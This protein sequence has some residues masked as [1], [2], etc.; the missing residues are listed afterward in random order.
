MRRLFHGLGTILCGLLE[1]ERR[2]RGID[3]TVE[4]EICCQELCI[5]QTGILSGTH[6]RR[7]NEDVRR[8][9]NICNR[10]VKTLR[11]KV[12]SEGKFEIEIQK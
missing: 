2:I 9:E 1:D 4:I 12:N 11:L 6:I 3:D 5:C 8:M 10:Y 7:S